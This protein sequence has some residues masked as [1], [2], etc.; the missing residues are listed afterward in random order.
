MGSRYDDRAATPDERNL[1]GEQTGLDITPV[2]LTRTQAIHL[3]RTI[4]R[5]AVEHVRAK[6][7]ELGANAPGRLPDANEVILTHD[8][9]LALPAS[10]VH[11]WRPLW[12]TV[13]ARPI[14]GGVR[15]VTEGADRERRGEWDVLANVDR[16]GLVYVQLPGPL[17]DW[18]PPDT[19]VIAVR[20]GDVVLLKE[21]E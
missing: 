11:K 12:I 8:R 1:L 4:A 20:D 2:A 15:L 18:P 9:R 21:V 16:H 19:K 6:L 14:P 17:R 10:A 7:V 13:T 5:G 3:L